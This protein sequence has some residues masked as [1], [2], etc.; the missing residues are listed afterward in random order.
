MLGVVVCVHTGPKLG[1]GEGPEAWVGPSRGLPAAQG[2]LGVVVWLSSL[3]QGTLGVVVHAGFF[4]VCAGDA[5]SCSFW[6]SGAQRGLSPTPKILPAPPS[7]GTGA[8]GGAAPLS[9]PQPQKPQI[10]FKI[11]QILLKPPKIPSPSSSSRAAPQRLLRDHFGAVFWLFGGSGVHPLPLKPPKS[12]LKPP[13]F[14]MSNRAVCRHFMLKGSCRYENNCAFYHP[15]VN[16][17]PL[18]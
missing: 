7:L 13:K 8:G 6:G 11:P 12:S 18:P 5:G 3:Q 14:Y 1:P 16:G 15:G 10:L 9:P 4:C 2:T 17:P